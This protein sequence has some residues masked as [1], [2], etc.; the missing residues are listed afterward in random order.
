MGCSLCGSGRVWTTSL[1]PAFVDG[2]IFHLSIFEYRGDGCS[3]FTCTFFLLS[4]VSYLV[5]Y[6]DTEGT[7]QRLD[8]PT[9]SSL[10]DVLPRHSLGS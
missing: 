8:N 7:A 2:S 6:V 9:K 4:F 1:G 5:L 3:L 10:G